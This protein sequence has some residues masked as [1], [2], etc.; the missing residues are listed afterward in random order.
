MQGQL[1]GALPAPWERYCFAADPVDP[2]ETPFELRFPVQFKSSVTMQI[3]DGWS[4]SEVPQEKK[5]EDAFTGGKI[6]CN[7][8]GREFRLESNIQVAPGRHPANAYKAYQQSRDGLL[9][10]LEPNLVLKPAR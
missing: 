4:V 10:S 9:A 8:N 7:V 1:I 2:R 6:A 3:A 5:V